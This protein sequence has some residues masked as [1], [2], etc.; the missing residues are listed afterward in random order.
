MVSALTFNQTTK[1]DYKINKQTKTTGKC[2]ETLLMTLLALKP[3][4]SKKQM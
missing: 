2:P 4:T 1:L 3:E